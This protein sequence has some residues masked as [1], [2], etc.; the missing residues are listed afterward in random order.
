[1]IMRDEHLVRVVDSIV[2]F[3]AH[4]RPSLES[5]INRNSKRKELALGG[6]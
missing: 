2:G 5:A 3:T 6:N 1:M 4:I